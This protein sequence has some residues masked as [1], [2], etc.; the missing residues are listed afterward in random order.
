M[1][2]IDNESLTPEQVDQVKDQL[3]YLLEQ[4]VDDNYA[5]VEN[6]DDESIYEDLGLD[7]LMEQKEEEAR[8]E[9]KERGKAER[10]NGAPN[11]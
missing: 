11:P 4:M 2:L 3:D 5:E 8:E 7:E 9:E 1:R 6:T 10:G